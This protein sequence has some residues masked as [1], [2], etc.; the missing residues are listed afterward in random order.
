VLVYALPPLA[1]PVVA[2]A[3]NRLTSWSVREPAVNRVR[4]SGLGME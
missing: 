1:L 3:F 2:W 4:R